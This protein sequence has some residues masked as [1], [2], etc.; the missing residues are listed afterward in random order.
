MTEE[1]MEEHRSLD[2]SLPIRHSLSLPPSHTSLQTKQ[3]P[4][5]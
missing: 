4:W 3:V 5:S 2:L 1:D